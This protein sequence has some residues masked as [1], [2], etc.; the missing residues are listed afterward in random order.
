MTHREGS[1]VVLILTAFQSVRRK[2]TLVQ[3]RK[4]FKT[5]PRAAAIKPWAEASF[6]APNIT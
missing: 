6:I 1:Q 4:H 2:I 5:T 3:I